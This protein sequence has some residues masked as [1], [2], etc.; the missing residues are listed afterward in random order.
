MSVGES[1]RAKVPR[2]QG[3]S[4]A[5]DPGEGR[6]RQGGATSE[7]HMGGAQKPKGRAPADWGTD[8][9][10]KDCP[11][12]GGTDSVGD[13]RARLPAVFLRVP[14]WAQ[15][16]RRAGRAESGDY[17][18]EGEPGVRCGHQCVLRSSGQRRAET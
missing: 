13:L 14:A 5:G 1:D 8:Y 6:A 15:P 4:D 3:K 2:T 7:G 16:A 11:S 9:R 18:G 17:P 10:G 12:R